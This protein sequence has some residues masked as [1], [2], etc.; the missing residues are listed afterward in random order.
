[1]M[2]GVYG[3]TAVLGSLM[4]NKAAVALLF[5]VVLTLAQQT[6]MD[7]LGLILCMT[8]AAAA[9]FLSPVGFQTNMMVYGPGGYSFKDFFR[10]GL[11]LTVM[12]MTVTVGVLSVMY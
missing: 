9:N 12:Y 10:I 2:I 6:G 4:L 5:P 7:P 1:V 3:V 11:P 8:F